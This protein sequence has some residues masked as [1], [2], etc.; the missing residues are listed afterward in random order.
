MAPINFLRDFWNLPQRLLLATPFFG[1]WKILAK[2]T[3]VNYL[4]K[5]QNAFVHVAR[6]LISWGR[7]MKISIPQGPIKCSYYTAHSSHQIDPSL[8]TLQILDDGRGT[9]AASWRSLL[10]DV[11][12]S[13]S[14]TFS[15]G[16][17]ELDLFLVEGGARL[18]QTL[19]WNHVSCEVLC[20]LYLLMS[21]L[22]SSLIDSCTLETNKPGLLPIHSRFIVNIVKLLWS[23]YTVSTVELPFA[24][25]LFMKLFLCLLIFGSSRTSCYCG[26]WTCN[27]ETN[28]GPRR[29]YHSQVYLPG[30]SSSHM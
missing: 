21:L 4:L 14:F 12:E 20:H 5:K 24:R 17:R 15:R 3:E 11:E 30:P 2:K 18:G 9:A 27:R 19:K 28:S 16:V 7:Q 13:C 25:L 23:R 29:I 10:P 1:I 22:I 6:L 8:A 26:C